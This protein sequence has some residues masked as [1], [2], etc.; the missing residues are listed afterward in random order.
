[1][2]NELLL[3]KLSH[4]QIKPTAVRLLVLNAMIGMERASSLSDL[5]TELDTVD[6]ST[7]FR[8]IN[9]FLSHHLIH[10]IDDGSGSLKYAVCSDRCMCSIDDLHPHF[11]CEICHRTFC[12]EKMHIPVVTLPENFSL[13]SINYVLKGICGACQNKASN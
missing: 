12:L 1:M 8:T 2:E 3:E 13:H 7:I 9:L 5:E 10:A 6:K 11:Y 4:R